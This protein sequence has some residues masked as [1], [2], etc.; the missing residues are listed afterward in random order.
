MEN[1]FSQKELKNLF[2]YLPEFKG[3][4]DIERAI[5]TLEHY[6]FKYNDVIDD[7]PLLFSELTTPWDDLPLK[8]NTNCAIDKAVMMWRLKI[9]K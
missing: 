3:N 7:S 5:N 4:L 8:I 9:G 2:E 6:N 1:K